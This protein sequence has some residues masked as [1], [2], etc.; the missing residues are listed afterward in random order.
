MRLHSVDFLHKLFLNAINSD[1]YEVYFCIFAFTHQPMVDAMKSRY[2]DYD[3]EVKGVF[4]NPGKSIEGSEFTVMQ[5]NLGTDSILALGGRSEI[6]VHH[7]YMLI[8]SSHP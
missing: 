7:K 4:D 2:D 6:Y 1:D 5:D 8:D 3:V